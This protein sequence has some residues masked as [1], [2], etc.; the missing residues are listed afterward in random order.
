MGYF[1]IDFYINEPSSRII[2]ESAFLEKESESAKTYSIHFFANVMKK[3]IPRTLKKLQTS[4][5]VGLYL[6]DS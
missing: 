1:I 4:K 6:R 5:A 2:H 3:N